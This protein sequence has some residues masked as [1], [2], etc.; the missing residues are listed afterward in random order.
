MTIHDDLVSWNTGADSEQLISAGEVDVILAW[1]GRA[2][3]SIAQQGA[4]FAA[5]YGE[6][7]VHYDSVVVPKGVAD[8]EAAMELVDF[9]MRA[10][11][12]AV[13]TSLIP[14][15]PTNQEAEL[16]ELSDDLK[17]FLPNTNPELARG[18][19]VQDQR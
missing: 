19:I 3:G 6:S 14:Y 5:A 10:D 2:Y 1:N 18:V 4:Q 9:M 17:E 16:G 13:L 8:P 7:F 15:A 11:R 12:Q